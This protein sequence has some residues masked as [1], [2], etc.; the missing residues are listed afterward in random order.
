MDQANFHPSYIGP[1]NDIIKYIPNNSYKILDIGCS[2]GTLG[3]QIKQERDVEVI[4]I[5]IDKNMSSVAQESLD[6]VITVDVET[7]GLD[8]YFPSMYFD[9][10]ILADIIEHLKDPWSL[11][12][13]VS[14]ILSSNGLVIASIPNIRHYTTIIN[15]VMKG[16]WPYR[17]RGIHDKTH[18]RFF[19]WKNIQELFSGSG[20]RISKV[21]RKYRLLEQPHRY[22][23]YSK[24][25]AFPVIKEFLTFQYIVIAKK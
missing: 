19:T 6:K 7:L 12:K 16:Y 24:F 1:R 2:I 14:S 5:E 25:F 22:N 15:L 10:V 18:L 13:N 21:E 3:K 20:L 23:K 8:T 9:C 17:D 11:L 4:G